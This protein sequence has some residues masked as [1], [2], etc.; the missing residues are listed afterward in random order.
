MPVVK[1]W[2]MFPE[3]DVTI[4]SH[5]WHQTVKIRPTNAI[6]TNDFCAMHALRLLSSAFS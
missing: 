4:S 2:S 1:P 3:P 5:F 6:G